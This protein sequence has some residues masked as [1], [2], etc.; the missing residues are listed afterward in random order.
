[1]SNLFCRSKMLSPWYSARSACYCF[2]ILIKA[3]IDQVTICTLNR[4]N[5]VASVIL[6]KC[7]VKFISHLLNVGAGLMSAG[8][9]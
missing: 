2:S 5:V 8:T 3:F 6:V 7:N 4:V 1:M 9:P